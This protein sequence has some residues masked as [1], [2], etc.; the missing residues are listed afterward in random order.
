MLASNSYFSLFAHKYPLFSKRRGRPVSACTSCTAP[1]H[2]RRHW[3][4]HTAQLLNGSIEVVT[5]AHDDA[6]NHL[7]LPLEEIKVYTSQAWER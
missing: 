7:N 1:T 3:S 2:L 4:L 5:C 6:H